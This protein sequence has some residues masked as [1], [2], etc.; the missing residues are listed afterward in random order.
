MTSQVL[1]IHLSEVDDNGAFCCPN[2]GKVL[3]PDDKEN[4]NYHVDYANEDYVLLVC[5]GCNS[6]VKLILKLE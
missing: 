5:H 4:E 6:Q 1:E 3:S 2:C